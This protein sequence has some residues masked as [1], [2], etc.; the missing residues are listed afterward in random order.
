[1]KVLIS[2]YFEN[3]ISTQVVEL[4]KEEYSELI[5]KEIKPT[6]SSKIPSY[7]TLVLTR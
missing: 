4:T 5:A 1:M 6:L 3:A 7:T 2:V